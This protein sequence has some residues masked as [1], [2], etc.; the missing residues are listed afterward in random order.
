LRRKNPANF[1]MRFPW[2]PVA[3]GETF[4]TKTLPYPT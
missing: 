2:P 3:E 1:L 4:Q